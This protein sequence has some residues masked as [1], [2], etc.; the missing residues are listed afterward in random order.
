MPDTDFNIKK[1][2]KNNPKQLELRYTACQQIRQ[3]NQ[4]FTNYLN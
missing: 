1:I 2:T 4:A 3:M